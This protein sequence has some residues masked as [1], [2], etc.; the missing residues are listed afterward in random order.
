MLYDYF[1]PGLTIPIMY[2]EIVLTIFL[3]CIIIFWVRNYKFFLWKFFALCFGVFAFEWITWALW[4]NN[5]LWI[6][7]YIHNDISFIMTL[8]WACL[9]MSFKFL[10]DIIFK[11]HSKIGYNFL[12]KE[13]IFVIFFS[14]IFWIMLLNY[15]MYIWSF[16]YWEE[17]Q[18]IVNSWF[19]IFGQPLEI[20]VYFP[21]FIFITF[22][23]YKYWELAIHNKYLFNN[24]KI[25][26]FKDIFISGTIIFLIWY[27]IHPILMIHNN[28]IYIL[29]IIAFIINLAI[30]S[31][32]ISIFKWFPLFQRFIA[33]SFIFTTLWTFILS[34]SVKYWYI[35]FSQ[36]I[37]N[38]H[39]INTIQ[40]PFTYISDVEFSWIL[41]LSFLLI[42]VTKYFKIITDN[43]HIEIS[44]NSVSFKW[45]KSL[46][47]NPN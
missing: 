8:T 29:M 44:N 7:T 3:I 14:S 20:I 15:L 28:F 5:H 17:I 38:T 31:F 12:I 21:V 40:I 34:S 23:F 4:I 24:Y 13:F 10:F 6:Y 26:F 45:F 27:L 25:S 1:N 16:S 9:I 30:T 33:G 19:L 41:L 22:T 11:K 42:A 37:I 47:S 18:K 36:S 39:T 35:S 43:K 32:I 46:F 2:Y